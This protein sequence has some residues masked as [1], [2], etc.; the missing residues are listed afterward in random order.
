MPTSRLENGVRAR[1]NC[2]KTCRTCFGSGKAKVVGFGANVIYLT[3]MS[4]PKPK[5]QHH[6]DA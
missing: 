5:L 2:T 1:T 4:G 3:A 6:D